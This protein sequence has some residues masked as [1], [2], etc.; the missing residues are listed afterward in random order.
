MGKLNHFPLKLVR[1]PCFDSC[2]PAHFDLSVCPSMSQAPP[3]LH[4]HSYPRRFTFYVA[5][6][7][8]PFFLHPFVDMENYRSPKVTCEFGPRVTSPQTTAVGA[9]KA[10]S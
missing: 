10:V 7:F 4:S 3:L 5:H 9:T 1:F 8:A 6:P 2:A